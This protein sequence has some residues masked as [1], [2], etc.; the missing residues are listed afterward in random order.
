MGEEVN[1]H[2]EKIGGRKDHRRR[3]NAGKSQKD[4]LKDAKGDYAKRTL[5]VHKRR[6][7]RRK[8]EGAERGENGESLRR[9][10]TMGGSLGSEREVWLL[11]GNLRVDYKN[12]KIEFSNQ[13]ITRR[14]GS[15]G[16]YWVA[17]SLDG[18]RAFNHFKCTD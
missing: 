13:A 9:S 18:E 17:T 10:R 6:S 15:E 16:L 5:S 4:A 7:Q 1:P 8:E 14:D 11:G 12:T 2:F 3:A